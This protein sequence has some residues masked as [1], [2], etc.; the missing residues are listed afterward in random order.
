MIGELWRISRHS[1][2]DVGQGLRPGSRG[3]QLFLF[4]FLLFF[5]IGL[6]LIL[7]GFDLGQVDLWLEGQSGWLDAVGSL[8]FRGI[9]GLVLLICIAL[10]ID[11]ILRRNRPDSVHWGCVPGLLLI[12]Y[13][14]WFG[15]AYPT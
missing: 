15:F 10:A 4:L 7:F 12:A 5:V 1:W 3:S 9:C 13:F 8:I 2:V 11:K 14:A 6:A